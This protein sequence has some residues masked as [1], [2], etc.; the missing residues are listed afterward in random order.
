MDLKGFRIGEN[1]VTHFAYPFRISH[2]AT[3]GKVDE[4]WIQLFTDW[5]RSARW[6]NNVKEMLLL[7]HVHHMYSS[8][9]EGT[10]YFTIWAA[11]NK[12]Q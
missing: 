7:Q 1:T 2:R 8:L 11:P 3:M 4:R 6:S 12:T 9:L 5:A 10:P